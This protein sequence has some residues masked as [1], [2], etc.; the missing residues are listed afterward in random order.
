MTLTQR[1]L[2]PVVDV[3]KEEASALLL[4]FLYS[5]L[6]MTS[7]NIVKPLTR[8]QFINDLG[9]DNLPWVLLAAGV[10]IAVI[11]QVFTRVVSRLPPKLVIP[12][13]QLG[14]V[15]LLL[16]FWVLFQTG[17]SWASIAFYFLGQI[18]G[19]LLI[20]HFW[21]MAN[22]VYDPRQAK[23]LFG[24]IGGGAS[25]GG[26]AGSAALTF[27]VRSVGTETMILV[28]AGLL[29]AC[30]FV[31]GAVGKV[32]DVGL[33]DI[34]KAGSKS[35]VGAG[36][37]LRLLRGSRHLQVIA[38]MIG[39]AAVGAGLLEQQLNM[40]TEETQGDGGADAI[41]A[42]LGTVQ[43][44]LS[45][46]G[47]VIQIWLTSRIHRLLGI[48]FAL[49]ILPVSLA[50]TGTLILVT[51]TLWAAAAGRILD[52]SLRYSVDKTTREI[53]FLPLPAELKHKV[54][55][56]VDVTVDRF[57]KAILAVLLLILIQGFGFQWR[58]LSIV[59]ITMVGLWIYVA[60]KARQG[61]LAS[62]RE[63][64]ARQG[65][66]PTT[67]RLS[68]A[69]LSTI[70]TLVEELAHP[71]E[72]HVLYAI[73]VLDSLDKRHLITP[74]L[75]H[76]ESAPVR[77][78]ALT[79]LKDTR[80][81]IAERWVPTIEKMIGDQSPEVRAAAIGTLASIRNEDAAGIARSLL[82]DHDARIVATAAVVL[83]GSEQESDRAA[84]Q[85]ALASL[86]ADTR[87]GASLVRRDL[88]AAIRQV[89][90]TRSHDLLIPLLHDPDPDVADEAMRSV[91]SLGSTDFMFA[92]TLVSLL[93]HRRLK[94][95]AREA[96][97][98]YGPPVLDVLK[99]FLT[100][101]EEDIWVRRHIP[102]TLA[103]IPCQQSMDVLTGMM[104]AEDGFLRFKVLTAIE[105]LRR[106]HPTLTFDKDPIESAALREGRKYF[107]RLGLHHNLFVRAKLPTGAVLAG[108]LNEKLERTVDRLYRLLGLLYPWKDISAARWAIEHGDNRA[109]ASALEYLDNILSAQLRHRVM[110]VLEEMPLEEKV[111]RGNVLLKTRPRDVEET[112][113]ELINDDD[114]VVAAS[115]I[116]LVGEL[117]MW[118]LADDVEHVLS[119]RDPKDWYVFESASWT[120]AGRALTAAKRRERWL[121][122]LPA[123]AIA[124]RMRTL[125][126]FALVGL[127]ELFRI[128]GAGHQVR[129]EIGTTLLREGA[130]PESLHLLL[131]GRVVATGRRAGARE[132]TSPAALGFE[133]ALD[134]CLMAETVKTSEAAVSIALSAD[135]LR[136]LLSDN[137]D[138]VQGLFRTLAERRDVKP[139]FIK[140]DQPG[141][142][143][144][145]TGEL[146]PIQKGLALQKIGL[147]SKVSGTEMLYLAAIARQI[148]LEQDVVLADE[149][150]PFGL[151]ILLS[152]G[153]ALR[154]PDAPEPVAQAG[155]GDS[156][157]VYE[158]LAGIEAV[159][160]VRKLQ[161]VVSAPGSALR[162]ER[163][164]LFDLLGQRPDM[165]QQLFTAIFDRRPRATKT[166]G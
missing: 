104:T 93:G 123:A 78:R 21:T 65:V 100:D 70:E 134:G 140:T 67:V 46:A 149:T 115:A 11:M 38:L 72:G 92:P 15:A 42:F 147:F 49:L 99:Y 1:L 86:A 153:L 129:H 151:G 122:P 33:S 31:V 157:G 119:H 37:A 113:L 34:S 160:Q 41:A 127:D 63:T 40:A 23:R 9:A 106:E 142:F 58:E 71:D 29:F 135:E 95:G 98:A 79:A 52:S 36:E 68:V 55:A 101:A 4:M 141:E 13:T 28:S 150:G 124:T 94:S 132:I 56:F 108:A 103:L 25:L 112:L 166:I 77:A 164:E 117:E 102:A 125:P 121:E 105:K 8:A 114:Q 133:E 50:A 83:S 96:L 137:T 48:G 16:G 97:V 20:S 3:R 24:F 131:D 91:R 69:D 27:F 152:G 159:T 60:I 116:D 139:G 18:M 146:T 43:L 2:S 5:F 75:L 85:K 76:H 148:T 136:T 158:T 64:I 53:L 165:L 14:L 66:E 26:M 19:L 156:I 80:S 87:Q 111:R 32:A 88:A 30:V 74:L 62:F 110:P 84:A 162:I 35:G 128:V 145:L 161:M 109:R 54:K 6:V 120:L 44:Y 61:Y 107:N 82:D 118:S 12:V 81:D 22:D 57:A 163:D 45:F 155:P 89:D 138:L 10:L 17:Q 143:E 7:Y 73:D 130:V 59:S 126:L 144:R 154:T 90:D 47:F 51:G 39:F